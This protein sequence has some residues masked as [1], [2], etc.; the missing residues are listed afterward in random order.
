MQAAATIST[1]IRARAIIKAGKSATE[2]GSASAQLPA[3]AD[4]TAIMVL[5]CTPMA[6]ADRRGA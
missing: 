1:D 6:V 5:D 3:V 2:R 4:V